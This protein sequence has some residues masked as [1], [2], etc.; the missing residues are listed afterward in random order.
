MKQTINLPPVYTKQLRDEKK[1][2][3]LNMSEIIRRG[4]DLYFNRKKGE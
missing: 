1:A 4:L 3:G 2:T